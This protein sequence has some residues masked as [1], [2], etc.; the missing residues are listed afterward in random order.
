MSKNTL[1]TSSSEIC[2]GKPMNFALV[3]WPVFF[4]E[5][6]KEIKKL[7]ENHS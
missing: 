6:T 7:L 5:N 3:L 1:R 4:S 2:L